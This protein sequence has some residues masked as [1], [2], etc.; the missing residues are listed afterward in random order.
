ML[1]NGKLDRRT[2]LA[3][4]PDQ[5]RLEPK[6]NFV[7][8]RTQVEEVVATAWSEFLGIE[9]VS[10]HD[11]FFRLGGHSLLAMHVVSRL[12]TTL[13]VEL[14]LRSFFEAPTI[15]G[16]ADIIMQLKSNGIGHHMSPIRSISR[17]KHRVTLS[18]IS[19]TLGRS[20]SRNE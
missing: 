7:A 5:I 13:Q 17:E 16:L 4:G 10:I 8:P 19:P 15:A 18:S 11:D 6:Q 20:G 14:P 3:S 9:Q 12:R 1:P 2:L